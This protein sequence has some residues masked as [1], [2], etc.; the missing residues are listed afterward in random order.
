MAG[1]IKELLEC[2]EAKKE[3]IRRRL[4]EFKNIL[5]QSDERIF[6]ELAFCICTPQSRA[7]I[8]WKAISSLEKNKLL[9]K[10]D[11]EKIRPFLN[12]VRFGDKKA[13][14]I[15]EA[16]NL[17]TENEKLKIKDRIQSIKDA[18]ELREWLVENVKGLGFKE[19]SHFLRNIGLGGDLAIL[20]V[21]ILKNLK[22]YGVIKDMPK[23]LTKKAYLKTES[24]MKEFS[25][26]VRIP[27]ENL[28]LL[29]W[30]KETGIIFK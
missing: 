7:T 21:H 24:A 25:Q 27:I 11:A 14:Y 29:L 12:A 8:C 13:S 2:Y 18:F 10:G 30:S 3:D 15:V 20:D 28:D 4:E 1:S 22:E 16:R 5:S 9:Y 17:F 6:A 26:S 23:C 19:A